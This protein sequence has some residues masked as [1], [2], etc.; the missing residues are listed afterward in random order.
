MHKPNTFYR[1]AKVFLSK[2]GRMTRGR[3]WAIM[4]PFWL[5]FWLLFIALDSAVGGAATNILFVVFLIPTFFLSAKRLHDTD[6][7]AW[8]LAI[9]LIPVIGP[10]WAFIELGCRKSTVGDNR[11]GEHPIEHNYD[12]LTNP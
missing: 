11:Y 1:L 3:Y 7:S 6:K 9:I 12:Y 8:W 10:I 4:M 5:L 2:E